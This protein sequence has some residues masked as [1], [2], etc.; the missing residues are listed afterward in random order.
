[1]DAIRS[2]QIDEVLN[3]DKNANAMVLNLEKKNTNA[4]PDEPFKQM[5]YSSIDMEVLKIF[6][7]KLQALLVSLDGKSASV[8]Q[9]LESNYGSQGFR[10][11]VGD[12]G[13]IEKLMSNYNSIIRP[14]SSSSISQPTRNKMTS[15]LH[16]LLKV[17]SRIIYGL[18][19]SIK[20]LVNAINRGTSTNASYPTLIF[21]LRGMRRSAR[22][23]HNLDGANHKQANRKRRRRCAETQDLGLDQQAQQMERDCRKEECG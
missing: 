9:I 3:Y 16:D 10:M 15:G 22:L 7:E 6:Q 19:Q 20:G 1:M 5:P 18:Q 12:I 17:V 13:E 14:L 4:F 2:R 21:F 23:L 8:S 11:G